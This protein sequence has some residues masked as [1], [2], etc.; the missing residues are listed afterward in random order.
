MQRR[1]LSSHEWSC[2][3][4]LVNY[5]KYV[6]IS[7][8]LIRIVSSYWQTKAKGVVSVCVH[9]LECWFQ[10]LQA[11]ERLTEG[12]VVCSHVES[13]PCL[14]SWDSAGDSLWWL[15][16]ERI[17]MN[18]FPFYWCVVI[19]VLMTF[20]DLLFLELSLPLSALKLDVLRYSETSVKF[21]WNL[22]HHIP[23]V[24][25]RTQSCVLLP[26]SSQNFKPVSSTNSKYL[27][28]QSVPG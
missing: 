3:S 25:N 7:S 12:G 6:F 19:P 10:S 26:H 8:T 13:F 16:T 1:L 2:S 4:G 20:G 17:T 23:V 14:M 11:T 22:W 28:G 27:S 15:N 21:Y 18:V 9:F 5:A 24:E